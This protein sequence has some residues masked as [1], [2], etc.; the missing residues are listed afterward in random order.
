MYGSNL[1]DTRGLFLR[2]HGEQWHL[3]NNGTTIGETWTLHQSG[4]LGERQG[5]GIRRIIGG[6]GTVANT[7]SNNGLGALQFNV[8]LPVNMFTNDNPTWGQGGLIVD[9]S[10]VTPT[11]PENRPVN[12]A[13]RFII[14]AVN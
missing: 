12:M 10:L 3:Q 2:G 7:F 13:A 9:S 4:T 8:N 5:D 11:A 6:V 14:K 1:P